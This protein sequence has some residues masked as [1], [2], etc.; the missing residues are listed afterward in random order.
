MRWPHESAITRRDEHIARTRRLSI[1][2]AGG[3]TA[4]SFALATA[5]GFALPGHSVSSGTQTSNASSGTGQGSGSGRRSGSHHHGGLAPPQQ[6]PAT[7]AAPPVV[8][9]GGS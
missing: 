2:V 1:W 6:P 4:A 9:S 5:L 7:S 3:S 8:S